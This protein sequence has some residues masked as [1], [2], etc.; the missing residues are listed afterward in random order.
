[1]KTNRITDMQISLHYLTT[2][3]EAM[4]ETEKENDTPPLTFE[5]NI[6]MIIHA[7]VV[8]KRNFHVDYTDGAFNY[9]GIYIDDRKIMVHADL[10][11]YERCGCAGFRCG[12]DNLRSLKFD[13]V[14]KRIT[15]V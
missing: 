9:I 14:L 1:M 6:A 7:C 4:Q 13:E 8:S 5:P 11:M 2:L 15:G 10:T 12:C 3:V